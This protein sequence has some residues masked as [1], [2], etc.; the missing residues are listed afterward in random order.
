MRSAPATRLAVLVVLA[1]SACA[2]ASE[3]SRKPVEG[4]QWEKTSDASV[5]LEAWVQRC[6]F[7]FRK[8]DFV[9]VKNALATRYSDS[10]GKPDPV[11][12]VFALKDGETAAAGVQRLWVERTPKALA[13]RCVRVELKTSEAPKG[14]TRFTFEPNPAYAAELKK[15]ALEGV[16]PPPC[17]EWG[18]LPDGFQYWETHAGSASKRVLF[19]RIGQDDPLYD[20]QTLRLLPRSAAP[21][22]SRASEVGSTQTIGE[23]K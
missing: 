6:D 2:A 13:P 23:V 9:F 10:T 18:T 4:C 19:V 21:K 12:E 7:G 17:G 3:P 1:A 11:I 15:A 5:G 20:E 8:I 22:G 14:V 16:P